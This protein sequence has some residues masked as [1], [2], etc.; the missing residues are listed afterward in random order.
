MCVKLVSCAC[1]RLFGDNKEGED[2][3]ISQSVLPKVC[4]PT[5]DPVERLLRC[6]AVFTFVFREDRGRLSGVVRVR[7]RV[8]DRELQGRGGH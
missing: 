3:D 6:G 8:R 7:E 4:V 1:S 2:A 5:L